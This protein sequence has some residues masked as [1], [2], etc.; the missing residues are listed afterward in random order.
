MSAEPGA[1]AGAATPAS[2]PKREACDLSLEAVITRYLGDFCPAVAYQPFY[3]T[4]GKKN[5]TFIELIHVGPCS[6]E[7]GRPEFPIPNE[8]WDISLNQAPMP[9]SREPLAEELARKACGFNQSKIE[10]V[11][12][13]YAK[14]RK[15]TINA[16]LIETVR[17]TPVGWC[18]YGYFVYEL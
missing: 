1:L 18:Y 8:F 14:F 5:N 17:L 15:S 6:R 13:C 3:T 10:W 9:K 7:K 2:R 11:G 4:Y 12:R 16:H